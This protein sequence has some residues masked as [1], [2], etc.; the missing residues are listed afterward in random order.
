MPVEITGGAGVND[1]REQHGALRG[2]ERAMIVKALNE[3]NW[4]QSR[5]AR[6]LGISRDNLRYRIKKYEIERGQ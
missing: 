2:F 4:N 5:A 3:C 1:D 6:M